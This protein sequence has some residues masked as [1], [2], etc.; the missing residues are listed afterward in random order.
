MKQSN[1]RSSF[2]VAG[3]PSTPK[4]RVVESD[5]QQS[6]KRTKNAHASRDDV[7]ADPVSPPFRFTVSPSLLWADKYKP[8]TSADLVGNFAAVRDLKEWLRN[9]GSS[10]G[11]PRA[12]LLSGPPGVGKSS[13]AAIVAREM[14][15]H[16]VE[17]NASDKR[18][19][20]TID[21]FVSQTMMNHTVNEF[22]GVSGNGISPTVRKTAVIMDEV[23]GMSSDDRG[24]LAQL[25]KIIERTKT[26]LICICNDRMHQKLKTL[27][28]HCKDIR[29]A[30]PS[31][32]EIR[33]RIEAIVA[34]EN[35]HLASG[36]I[37]SL[38]TCGDLRYLLNE[39]Q[40]VSSS[41]ADVIS[42]K[43][44]TLS[45]ADAVKKLFSSSDR[46]LDERLDY[47]FVDDTLVPSF[48]QDNY[49]S[50]GCTFASA[51]AASD[52]ISMGNVVDRCIRKSQ[53]YSLMPYH[54]VMSTVAPASFVRGGK[55]TRT[56]IFPQSLAKQS[57]LN[58]C[59]RILTELASHTQSCTSASAIE[60][61]PLLRIR[62]LT[63]LLDG[64]IS[65]AISFMDSYHLARADFDTVMD[66][67]EWNGK[68]TVSRAVKAAF[69]R[70]FNKKHPTL[71]ALPL[72]EEQTENAD[73]EILEIANLY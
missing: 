60:Y 12:A 41:S 1:L 20:A 13:A 66:L 67:T 45:P 65:D 22:F 69:T 52:W 55:I 51:V 6:A 4:K 59:R 15:Y 46:S 33:A 50:A 34:A 17:F 49:L 24:G 3:K 8:R 43:D 36:V 58:R 61:L 21:D 38:L 40:M 62:L 5:E 53:H 47:Y 42:S 68:A 9:W 7:T 23:D 11:T 19:K 32:P 35:L 27:A 14:G 10:K 63:P 2:F 71:S 48:V 72:D 37:D 29:F 31:P 25:V 28:A 70:A 16:V 54:G 18:N 26:P 44:I 39:L 73:R 30:R 57:H 56:M 64:R